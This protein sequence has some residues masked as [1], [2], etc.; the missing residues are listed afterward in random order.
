MQA[1]KGSARTPLGP[2][3]LIPL[4]PMGVLAPGSAHARPSTRPPIDTSGNF[5]AHVSAITNKQKYFKLPNLR[6]NLFFDHLDV[7]KLTSKCHLLSHYILYMTI[8]SWKIK[9][10]VKWT[11]HGRQA[12]LVWSEFRVR[13]FEMPTARKTSLAIKLVIVMILIVGGYFW[14]ISSWTWRNETIANT[15]PHVVNTLWVNLHGH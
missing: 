2:K 9:C 12:K 10:I 6:C 8:R 14:L 1:A 5:P 3:Y 13:P 15:G 11:L 7:D 4:A